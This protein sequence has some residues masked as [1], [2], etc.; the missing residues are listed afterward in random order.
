MKPA[1]CGLSSGARSRPILTW[2]ST[3]SM[4]DILP[5]PAGP[6]PG[7]RARGGSARGGSA[8]G[9]A[10]GGQRRWQH[11]GRR[12]RW[13][14]G[15]VRAA[16]IEQPGTVTVRD[17]ARAGGGRARPGPGGAGGPVRHRRQD[18]LRADPGA[19]AAGDGARDDRHGGGARPPRRCPR[20]RPGAGQPG[21]VLR[22][23]RPVPPGPAAAVPPRRAARPRRGRLLRGA[24]GGGRGLPASAPRTGC[25]R[26]T[27]ACCRCCPPA[28][29]RSPRCPRPRARWWSAWASAACCTFSCCGRAG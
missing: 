4:R 22:A 21:R 18:R 27:P 8:R 23:L 5:G 12:H 19:H 10:H 16:L 9:A 28:C 7:G 11:T 26:P 1:S 20:G 2:A 14:H 24:G 6:G 3:N 15:I 13:Q 25:P 17:V 29:T